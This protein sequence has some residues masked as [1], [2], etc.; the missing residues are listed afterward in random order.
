V[1]VGEGEWELPGT[2]TLPKGAGPFPAVV[3]VHGSGPNDRDETIGALKPFKDLAWGLAS[4]GVAVLRYDKRTLAHASKLATLMQGLTVKEETID[5]ALAAAALLQQTD[6][7]DPKRIFVLGHSLGGMLAPRIAAADRDIAG[8]VI[9]AGATR[10]LEDLIVEQS[11]YIAAL[12]GDVSIAERQ[13]LEAIQQAVEQIKALNPS[14]AARTD[15]ILGAP[16]SYWLDLQAYDPVDTAAQLTLPILILQGERDYQA[17]LQDFEGW[18]VGL[19]GRP[20]VQ[21]K[22]FPELNHL[23]VAGE[24]RSTPDEYQETGH[25]AE[26]VIEE[27]AAWLDAQK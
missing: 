3:L 12:D 2:L 7:I 6:T 13:Q 27:I 16:P 15:S 18:R 1:T 9:L 23:F 25:V 26:V 14:D 19:S 8:I 22:T 4:R 21:L 24:G 10:P 11:E 17:T 5:D 20:N